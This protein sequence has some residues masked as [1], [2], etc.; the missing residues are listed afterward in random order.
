M[1]PSPRLLTPRWEFPSGWR[2]SSGT[3]SVAWPQ[4]SIN[5][6]TNAAASPVKTKAASRRAKKT[7]ERHERRER[8]RKMRREPS[9]PAVGRRNEPNVP[10]RRFRFRLEQESAAAVSDAEPAKMEGRICVVCWPRRKDCS[11][12]IAGA[13]KVG[14]RHWRAIVGLPTPPPKENEANRQ[15]KSFHAGMNFHLPQGRLFRWDAKP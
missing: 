10:S 5:A 1:W 7:D 9:R 14:R 6:R 3:T 4:R 8:G 2:A 15:K 13:W 11:P 12:A